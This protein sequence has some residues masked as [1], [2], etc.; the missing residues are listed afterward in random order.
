MVQEWMTD[1]LTLKN[2]WVLLAIA[3]F[4][5]ALAVW[6]GIKGFKF[7]DWLWRQTGKWNEWTRKR[8]ND[9]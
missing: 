3:L 1:W 4:F 2:I 6:A 7:G 9:D 5:G 8:D